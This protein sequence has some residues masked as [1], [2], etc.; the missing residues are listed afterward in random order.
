MINHFNEESSVN[1]KE[2]NQTI[3]VESD[4]LVRLSERINF[5]KS[6]ILMEY[7]DLLNVQLKA[8]SDFLQE[9]VN[10]VKR[11]KQGLQLA[12]VN[13]FPIEDPSSIFQ[14]EFIEYNIEKPKYNED[15][16][17]E[18]ELTYAKPLKASLRLSSKANKDS[19]DY[20]DAIEQEVYL[21]NI[22]AMTS[23]GTFIINGAERV[24]VSQL[25]RSPGVFFDDALHP[26]GTRIYTARIICG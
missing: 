3:K 1:N 11:K 22:P 10:P 6:K 20:I 16:C 8:Y 12:F 18:R 14:L 15:E 7:P 26:N 19:E 13:N 24:I 21:G 9:E 23:R 25:H 4:G 17:R 2:N 5:A